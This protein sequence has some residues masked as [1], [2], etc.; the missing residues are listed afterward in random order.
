MAIGGLAWLAVSSLVVAEA[1]MTPILTTPRLVLRPLTK[2]T[3]RQVDWLRDP[4][5]VKYSEQRHREHTLTTCLRYIQSFVPHGHIWSI[6]TMHDDSHI[7]NIAADVDEPN[8]I[9]DL[10]IMI[11]A[12]TKWADGYGSEAWRGVTEW[13][14]DKR[15][16][17]LRKIEAGCMAVN[18][19]MRKVLDRTGYQFEGER[20]NHFLYQSNP[21]GALYYGKFR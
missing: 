2:A 4:Q 20:K 19:G 9:A 1:K 14:L 11:G 12:T 5:V 3:Q 13:L 6:W 15:A 8:N 21:T 17:N 10:S 18:A 7:G 16:G